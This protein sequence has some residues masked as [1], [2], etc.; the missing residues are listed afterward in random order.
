MIFSKPFQVWSL[1][2]C[3]LLTSVKKIIILFNSCHQPLNNSRGCQVSQSW[4]CLIF[5]I[6]CTYIE[7][8]AQH[9]LVHFE[10]LVMPFGLTNHIL[11]HL[12]C[13][14]LRW[15][16]HFL[17]GLG[18]DNFYSSFIWNYSHIAA[19]LTALTSNPV[20]FIQSPPS[21][22]LGHAEPLHILPQPPTSALPTSCQYELA[23]S[24]PATSQI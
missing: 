12:V 20:H 11:N 4:S 3:L 2:V 17:Q 5:S 13:H 14:L 8:C 24:T 16:S 19:P 23:S 21:C 9:P 22:A 10:Y 18:F 6:W 1:P 7:N 15:Q